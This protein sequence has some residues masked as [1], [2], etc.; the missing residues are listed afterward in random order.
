M[1]V[2]E[3]QQEWLETWETASGLPDDFDFTVN[4]AYFGKDSRYMNGEILLLI[5]EGVADDPEI[6][7]QRI[8]WPC[9]TGWD[10][11][12]NGKTAVHERGRKKFIG[13]SIYGRLINRCRELG[14]LEVL[15]RRG[16]ATQASVWNGTR[17]H[18]KRE[19]L[20]F[21]P[22]LEP[23]ERLMPVKFLGVV[24]E[25]VQAAAQAQAM[26]QA[27]A[28]DPGL[29]EKLALLARQSPDYQTFFRAAMALPGVVND[30][31]LLQEVMDETERG[32]YA[33]HR[34]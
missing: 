4:R 22:G 21:G 28:Q 13:S 29:R 7:E 2:R 10:T 12:D 30:S 9:G 34:A 20:E 8:I 3:V 14:A 5:W 1:A 23:V 6:G 19:T 26:V 25:A 31:V 16:P 24:G 27:G 32:F 17:W 18:L 11:P 15:A 33:R